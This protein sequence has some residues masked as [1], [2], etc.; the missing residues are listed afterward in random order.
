MAYDVQVRVRRRWRTVADLTRIG[1][2]AEA[3]LEVRRLLA[4]LADRPHARIVD[5]DDGTQIESTEDW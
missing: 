1:N 2:L 3:R 5:S 4:E